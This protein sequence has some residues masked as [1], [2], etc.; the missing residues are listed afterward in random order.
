MQFYILKE[1]LVELLKEEFFQ[2]PKAIYHNLDIS[3][4]DK[5]D[6]ESKKVQNLNN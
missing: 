6:N 2:F 5:E 4:S 1:E 3:N